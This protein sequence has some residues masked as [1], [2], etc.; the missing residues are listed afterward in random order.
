LCIASRSTS[1]YLGLHGAGTI[2][3]TYAVATGGLVLLYPA[4]RWYRSVKAAHP[5]SFLKYI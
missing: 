1:T 4:C 3:A 5:E 2:T